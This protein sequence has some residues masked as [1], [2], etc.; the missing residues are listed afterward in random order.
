MKTSIAVTGVVV[1]L[2][3]L[4]VWAV[5]AY[6]PIPT[7]T[8]TM[9]ST[10]SVIPSTNRN[11]DPNGDWSHGMT[12]QQ[13]ETVTG[14]A[15][16]QSFNSSAGPAF[17]YVMNES[18]FIDWGGC[19]PCKE[20][21]VAGTHLDTG[22]FQN[23]TMPASGTLQISYTAPTTGAYYVVFDNEAYGQ[24]AQA[25]VSA[26]GVASSMV[27]TASP[28]VGGYLPL[29]GAAV[30]VLG[31]IIAA[32]SVVMKGKPKMAPAPGPTQ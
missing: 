1:L 21:S 16:I 24:S 5:A 2:I 17:F 30:A 8:S 3:G 15:T 11:I 27:T 18:T 7:S 25:S 14:T 23:T 9:T 6:S 10:V 26:S 28:Y 12:L 4:G 20:P 19:A 31:I 29:L 13:G 32:L 22:T